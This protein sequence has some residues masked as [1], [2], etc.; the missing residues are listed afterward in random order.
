MSLTLAIDC[1]LR[2]IC[3]GLGDGDKTI[4]SQTVR[5]GPKQSAELPSRVDALLA[6][7]GVRLHDVTRV[8]VTVGPGYYTGI[9]VG[10]SY[11]CA[12]AESIGA[13]AVPI[14]T[15]RAMSVSCDAPLV[16]PVIRAREGAVYSAIY[17]DGAEEA[18]PF[19]ADVRDVIARA[20]AEAS[21]RGTSPT[22]VCA[23]PERTLAL[24]S[25]AG[26][27]LPLGE[28]MPSLM[29]REARK[30][31]AVDPTSIRALYLRAPD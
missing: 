8:A 28:D 21:S 19:F 5:S 4:A 15:L 13:R 18:S 30:I 27:A 20:Q 1:A 31:D 10:M 11:A 17:A 2:M 3:I 12:L 24:F 7:A 16:V 6:S 26:R 9:R 23:E 22:F 25:G 14:T 29:L